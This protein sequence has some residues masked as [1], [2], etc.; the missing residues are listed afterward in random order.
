MSLSRHSRKE[1]RRAGYSAMIVALKSQGVADQS[2]SKNGVGESELM[3]VNTATE[4]NSRR[5]FV[6]GSSIG[7]SSDG[8]RSCGSPFSRTRGRET[9]F[10]IAFRKKVIK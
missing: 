2:P 3:R 7:I 8:R 4:K 9:S 1:P 10:H 5:E 6:Q